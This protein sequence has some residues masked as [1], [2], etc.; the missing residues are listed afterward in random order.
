MYMAPEVFRREPYNEKADIFSLG[1][2]LYQL[3]ARSLL[4]FTHTR[5]KSAADVERYAEKVSRGYRPKRPSK[6]PE[7]LYAIIEACWSHEPCD[8]PGITW[9]VQQLTEAL[10]QELGRQSA[11]S[12]AIGA[13]TR[14]SL[15]VAGNMARRSVGSTAGP[16]AANNE[17][18]VAGEAG[19]RVEAPGGCGCVVM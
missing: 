17:G 9:V 10:E 8:R 12:L 7:H 3:L 2:I 1:V 6:M 15:G 11:G 13:L 5:A 4:L 14:K 18:A 16:A 19:D